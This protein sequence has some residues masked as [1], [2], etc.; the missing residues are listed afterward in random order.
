MEIIIYYGFVICQ[1]LHILMDNS[2]LTTAFKACI[3]VTHTRRTHWSIPKW[4]SG[5]SE[6]IHC[7]AIPR[8]S[9]DSLSWAFL[10]CESCVISQDEVNQ[11]RCWN[12]GTQLVDSRSIQKLEDRKIANFRQMVKSKTATDAHGQSKTGQRQAGTQASKIAQI[13]AVSLTEMKAHHEPSQ[14]RQPWFSCWLSVHVQHY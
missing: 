14:K 13:S 10:G 7:A 6:Q 12:W 5:A 3:I 11:G 4:E 9:F 8:F 1:A 2:Q